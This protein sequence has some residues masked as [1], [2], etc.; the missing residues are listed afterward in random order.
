MDAARNHS[1]TH[2]LHKALKTVLGEH[3]NQ[4]GSLVAPDRLRFDFTH[5]ESITKDQL[6]EIEEMVNDFVL[7][8]MPITAEVMNINAAKEMGATALFGEKYGENVRVVT[9]GDCSIELC[10]GTHLDNTA[11]VGLFKIVSESGVAAGVRRIEAI[12]GRS[13]YQSIKD[14]D[15]LVAS[16]VDVLKTREDNLFERA[17]TIVE[18]NK[19]LEKELQAIKAKMSMENADSVLDS[20]IEIKGVNLITNRYEGMDMDTLRQAADQ[21]RD[22]LESG[23]VVL[24]NVT[25]G[26]INIVATASKEAIDKGAHAGNIVREVAKIAGGKGGGRPNM[27]QAGASDISKLDEALAAAKEIVEGQIK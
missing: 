3:V 13:V 23:V 27:A 12:T 26:K 15:R 16:V 11:Q 17:K 4:A 20:K 6:L 21:L 2:L 18:E 9:M 24:A 10:G 7:E 19:A 22:K 5:F 14:T 8:S 25:D 1:A